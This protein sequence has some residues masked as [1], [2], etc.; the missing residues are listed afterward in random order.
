MTILVFWA[1]DN[2][3]VDR[4]TLDNVSDIDAFDILWHKRDEL[5]A[6]F[7]HMDTSSYSDPF[8]R[9]GILNADE[10]V[11]DYNDEVLDGGKWTRVIRLDVADVK[12]IINE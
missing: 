9:Y 1:V 7:Y 8:G 2:D 6:R 4:H 5:N 10:F 11:E 12:R 3:K